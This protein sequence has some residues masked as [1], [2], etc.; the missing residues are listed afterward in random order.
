MKVKTRDIDVKVMF[1]NAEY[2]HASDNTSETAV[3][4]FEKKLA[5]VIRTY[6]DTCSSLVLYTEYVPQAILRTV[7]E[8]TG[9]GFSFFPV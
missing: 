1:L 7:A 8:E 4:V 2:G 5:A 3:D 6:F 9:I